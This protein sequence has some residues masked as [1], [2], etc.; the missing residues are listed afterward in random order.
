ML[1][2]RLAMHELQYCN[3]GHR[4]LV[5]RN[6]LDTEDLRDISIEECRLVISN[7]IDCNTYPRTHNFVLLVNRFNQ[8][9]RIV[10]A[11]G[12]AKRVREQ[13]IGREVRLNR[14]SAAMAAFAS[15]DVLRQGF[16]SLYGGDGSVSLLYL[17]F[18]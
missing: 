10:K 13:R 12:A 15:G 11:P 6:D 1:P 18:S 17:K 3:E 9:P 2:I 7:R 5:E 16:L 4:R 14:L 8:E